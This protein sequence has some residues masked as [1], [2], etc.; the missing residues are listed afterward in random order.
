MKFKLGLIALA[1]SASVALA[2]ENY[3]TWGSMR[4]LTINGSVGGGTVTKFPLLVRLT[5]AQADVFAN[6]KGKGADIRFT[7]SNL[8]TR[9]PHQI[10]RW[11]SAGQKAEIWVLVD[12]IAANTNTS[13]KML[14]NKAG[15]ADSSKG[16]AVFTTA[17][18]FVSVL[19]LGDSTGTN[20]RP[21]QVVGAPTGL[22]TNFG[23]PTTEDPTPATYVA[24]E[25]VI[26]RADALRGGA[27]D[28]L[29]GSHD[30]IDLNR[31]SY[32]GFSD[33][34]AGFTF[35]TWL[36]STGPVFAERFVEILD[37]T[38][39]SASSDTRIILFGNRQ[40]P[41]VNAFSVRWGASGTYNSA[42]D[43]L[44]APNAWYHLVFTK[45]AGTAP[46]TI[47]ANGVETDVTADLPD[48]AVGLR[49]YVY[50]GRSSVTASDPYFQ[51]M[52]DEV[53]FAKAA[54]SAAWAKLSYETQ[55]AGANAIVVGTTAAPAAGGSD[56][57]GILGAGSHGTHSFATRV[58]GRQVFFNLP[59][60]TAGKVSVLDVF[61]RTVWSSN[62]TATASAI[63][64]DGMGRNGNASRGVYVARFES[65]KG[66]TLERKF[67]YNP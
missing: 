19:H 1:M 43:N 40:N 6:S 23:M 55:K 50:M 35:S 10:E 5:S 12:S 22:L 57:T 3:S 61:G 60:A 42:V 66:A 41:A 29:A 33:F 11:D 24:P 58:A 67:A 2:Q 14:W 59:A 46:M 52:F 21:N 28:N 53:S 7:K 13:I 26:G 48:L 36:Y 18:G 17:N 31:R 37:D 34:S 39:S 56:Y 64:W 62:V 25:G 16:S 30:F 38:T 47:Y 45:P 65:L 27:G 49:N 20:P 8:T 9:Y 32:E 15:A 54:R 44:Y 63:A 51:G 4:F